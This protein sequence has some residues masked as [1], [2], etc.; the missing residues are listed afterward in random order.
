MAEDLTRKGYL[1]RTIG[2][3]LRLTIFASSSAT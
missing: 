3:K 2:V 1:G